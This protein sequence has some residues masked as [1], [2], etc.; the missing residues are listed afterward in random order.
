M[1]KYKKRST[2]SIKGSGKTSAAKNQSQTLKSMKQTQKNLTKG[3]PIEVQKKSKKEIQKKQKRDS[4]QVE[5]KPI[6]RPKTA[7]PLTKAPRHQRTEFV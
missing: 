2:S 6:G 3:K 4:Q 7:D 1:G 5:K